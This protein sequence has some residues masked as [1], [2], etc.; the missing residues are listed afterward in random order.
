MNGR[1]NEHDLLAEPF[2]LARDEEHV[3]EE[4]DVHVHGAAGVEQAERAFEHDLAARRDDEPLARLLRERRLEEFRYYDFGLDVEHARP[5]EAA[6][7][8]EQALEVLE[9]LHLVVELAQARLLLVEDPQNGLLLLGVVGA[10]LDLAQQQRHLHD[11]LH[12]RHEQ[13]RQLE[14]LAAR[15]A[16]APLRKNNGNT[17][18]SRTSRSVATVATVSRYLLELAELDVP[19]QRLEVVER[20]DVVERVAVVRLRENLSLRALSKSRACQQRLISL[21]FCAPPAGAHLLEELRQDVRRLVFKAARLGVVEQQR[22]EL[23]AEAVRHLSNARSFQ[24]FSRDRARSRRTRPAGDVLILAEEIAWRTSPAFGRT[25]R[26]ALPAFTRK[27]DG[28]TWPET[29]A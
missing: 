16:V 25:R 15:V 21:P 14:L 24:S 9:P 10:L 28:E 6:L 19:A 17:N 2:L 8:L 1:R 5:D 3:V 27:P 22:D 12:G 13:V 29:M 23:L 7:D 11:V 18:L 26:F 4:D 20:V